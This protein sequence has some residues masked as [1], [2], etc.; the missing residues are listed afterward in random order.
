MIPPVTF[1]P[2]QI[3]IRKHAPAKKNAMPGVKPA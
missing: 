1:F 3:N 2:R